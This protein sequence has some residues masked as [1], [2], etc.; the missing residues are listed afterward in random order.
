MAKLYEKTKDNKN[1]VF[2]G[3]R[4]PFL[5]LPPQEELLDTYDTTQNSL[6]KSA[7]GTRAHIP[8]SSLAVLCSAVR[9]LQFGVFFKA[10]YNIVKNKQTPPPPQTLFFH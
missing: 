9:K 10:K 8:M 5:H 1:K 6:K 2:Q 7:I 4:V 3:N